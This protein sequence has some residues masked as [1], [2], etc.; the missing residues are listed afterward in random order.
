MAKRTKADK[1][2]EGQTPEAAQTESE[3]PETRNE[4]EP[5][6]APE[7]APAENNADP[8]KD[9]KAKGGKGKVPPKRKP[10]RIYIGPMIMVGGY[11]LRTNLTFTADGIPEPV[12]KVLKTDSDLAA[13][14][15]PVGELGLA[16]KR[17]RDYDP[18]L[19][20][21]LKAVSGRY[22]PK[23]KTKEG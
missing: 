16:K 2:N 5:P 11:P 18:D 9:A 22:G 8:A 12:E 19:G 3:A 1:T 6:E 20:R 10:G 7:T 15:V 14:F 4:T 13:L 21:S 23:P 17:L